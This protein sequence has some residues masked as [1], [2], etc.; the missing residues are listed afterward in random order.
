[1]KQ[2][3]KYPKSY[4]LSPVLKLGDIWVYRHPHSRALAQI[5]EIWEEDKIISFYQIA[6]YAI[7]NTDICLNHPE[8]V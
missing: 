2:Q 1:M 4:L 7:L 5:E 8:W 3:K 6:G